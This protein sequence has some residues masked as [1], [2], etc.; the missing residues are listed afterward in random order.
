MTYAV[1]Y[2]L[3]GFTVVSFATACQPVAVGWLATMATSSAQ[4]QPAA[5]A[6]PPMTFLPAGQE[7]T[8]NFVAVESV[9]VFFVRTSSPLMP[10]SPFGPIGRSCP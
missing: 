1:R 7:A 3:S 5:R 2:Q 4:P 6:P 10:G 9:A 8:M